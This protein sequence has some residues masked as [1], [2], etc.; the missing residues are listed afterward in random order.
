MRFRDPSFYRDRDCFAISK[1]G[2][3]RNGLNE[4]NGSKGEE[5]KEEKRERETKGVQVYRTQNALRYQ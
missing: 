3:G 5:E 2:Y 1:K 4:G